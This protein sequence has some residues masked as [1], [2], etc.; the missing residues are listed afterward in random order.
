[1][2]SFLSYLFFGLLLTLL[3]RPNSLVD[4][5]INTPPSGDSVVPANP[6]I[7]I[8]SDSKQNKPRAQRFL[9]ENLPVAETVQG[10]KSLLEGSS[11]HRSLGGGVEDARDLIQQQAWA[12][13]DEGKILWWIWL[14]IALCCTCCC[15]V[16]C[17]SSACCLR[18]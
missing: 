9:L 4:A 18:D 3:S 6:A 11:G 12:R 10:V 7:Q 8:E 14:I 1:M 13:D 5:R 16:C 2:R 15:L 17:V